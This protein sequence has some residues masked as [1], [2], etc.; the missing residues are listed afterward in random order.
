MR[1][2]PQRM[3]IF[4]Y[5]EGNKSHPSADDIYRAVAKKFPTISLATIY[6]TLSALE[7]RGKLLKLT[8]DPSKARY[9]PN[10][11]PHHHLICNLCKTIADVDTRYRLTLPD[12]D[13]EVTGSHVEFYGTCPKCGSGSRNTE[14]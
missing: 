8:I 11:C 10:T 7:R 9:D 6:N 5:L 1:L 14:N 4:D 13:F 3:A 2:T 12:T